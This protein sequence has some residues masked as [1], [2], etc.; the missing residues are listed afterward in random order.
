MVDCTTDMYWK[1][2]E[3]A[4]DHDSSVCDDRLPDMV[5]INILTKAKLQERGQSFLQNCTY[6]IDSDR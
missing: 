5:D 2:D 6:E 3:A 1:Y 4:K